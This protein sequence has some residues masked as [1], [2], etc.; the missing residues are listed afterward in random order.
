MHERTQAI[1]Q[2]RATCRYCLDNIFHCS[3][4]YICT[5]VNMH[6][7]MY[8]SGCVRVHVCVC[9]CVSVHV[10]VYVCVYVLACARACTYVS[11][12]VCN[13]KLSEL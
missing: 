12:F 10:C 1:Q 5:Y 9:E 7:H 2:E 8:V 11:M 13:D 6:V 3:S 4:T